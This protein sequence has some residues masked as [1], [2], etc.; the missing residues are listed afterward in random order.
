MR[1]LRKA[2]LIFIFSC[3]MLLPGVVCQSV[4]SVLYFDNTKQDERYDWLRKGIADILITELKTADRIRVVER[5]DLEKLIREQELALS[6][7]TDDSQTVRI[8]NLLHADTLIYG[9][10]IVESGSIRIDARITDTESGDIR[11]TF[12]AVGLLSRMLDWQ[13][14]LADAMFGALGIGKPKE[15]IYRTASLRAMESYYIGLNLMDLGETEKAIDKFSESSRYDVL[16]AKPQM[17]LEEAYLFIKDFRGIQKLRE[18][19]EYNERLNN[20]VWSFNTEFERQMA[21]SPEGLTLEETISAMNELYDLSRE[22][23]K[24]TAEL[25]EPPF[26][27]GERQPYIELQ[28][29]YVAYKVLLFE[30]MIYLGEHKRS[31]SGSGKEYLNL[32]KKIDLAV[33]QYHDHWV[34]REDTVYHRYDP[35]YY[36]GYHKELYEEIMSKYPGEIGRYIDGYE[37]ALDRIREGECYLDEN[38][39]PLSIHRDAPKIKWFL[40]MFNGDNYRHE[41]GT[42]GAVLTDHGGVVFGD[43]DCALSIDR[44]TGFVRYRWADERA[45]ERRV[46]DY[47]NPPLYSPFDGGAVI[48]SEEN[49]LIRSIGSD[50]IKKYDFELKDHFKEVEPF[51]SSWS[52]RITDAS[53]YLYEM[54]YPELSR[55]GRIHF[56]FEF[57]P[58]SPEPFS[59]EKQYNV[60]AIDRD[61]NSYILDYETDFQDDGKRTAG[62]A[63]TY[64]LKKRSP[65]AEVL[66]RKSFLTVKPSQYWP[67]DNAF[68]Y[69]QLVLD[70]KGSVIIVGMSGSS[71][72]PSVQLYKVGS[73]GTL[74]W[75]LEL[76]IT[77]PSDDVKR[78]EG[79]RFSLP[80]V[81]SDDSIYLGAG[82]YLYCVSAQGE[83]MWKRNLESPIVAS[84]LIGN[85]AVVYVATASRTLYALSLDGKV[86]WKVKILYHKPSELVMDNQ[87]VLYFPTYRGLRA[88][89]QTESTGPMDSA[90]P[91]FMHD[92]Y[93]SGNSGFRISELP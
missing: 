16:Y 4:I 46:F 15:V 18:R 47:G 22:C 70:S 49:T 27:G 52:K 55:S 5:N 12:K 3:S 53:P 13:Q 10:F 65:D 64:S 92:Q 26:E 88:A 73:N 50:G 74:Q 89:L 2:S 72:S 32:L 44:E 17:S 42:R 19:A 59:S 68:L 28:A 58:T 63:W 25:G 60:G 23:R 24:I 79:N 90:W 41:G 29:R 8:G 69:N 85:A 6:D 11:K 82:N 71:D 37:A 80:V 51:Y 75:E 62:P 87:G 78:S 7:L 57:N 86:R 20:M 76:P 56:G 83:V 14:T 66:L 84:P 93:N 9:S 81:D 67:W 43:R 38:G 40:G 77:K 21:R 36:R 34:N 1:I 61:G 35:Y 33:E 91:M 48:L 31:P 30:K 45:S 54:G 39:T